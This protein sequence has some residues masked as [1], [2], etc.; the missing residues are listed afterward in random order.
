MAMTEQEAAHRRSQEHN[1]LRADSRTQML[2]QIFAF[3][4]AIGGISASV[5]LALTGHNAASIAMIGAPLA[6]I[7]TAFLQRKSCNKA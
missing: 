5:V 3:V 7:V 2:G 1:A 6:I 4:V